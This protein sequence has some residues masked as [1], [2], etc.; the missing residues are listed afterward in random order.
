YPVSACRAEK[1]CK[2]YRTQD[3]IGE[4]YGS[5]PR[6]SLGEH[7]MDM[8]RSPSTV[9]YNKCIQDSLKQQKELNATP[10]K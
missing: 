2:T 6:S 8:T 1:K 4:G 5:Q 7:E 9:A 3:N 10:S